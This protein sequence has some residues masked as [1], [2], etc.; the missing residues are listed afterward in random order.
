MQPLRAKVFISCGQKKDTQEVEV[1]RAIAK[2]L[3]SLGFDTYIAVQEQTLK[4]LKENIFSQLSTSEYFLFV[5]FPRE[6]FADSS[7]RRGS[8]FSHQELAIASYLDLPVIAFQQEGV[9]PL[10]GMMSILQA[11]AIPFDDAVKLPDMVREQV[12]KAGWRADWKN[13]LV[14]SRN[15]TEFDDARIT[16]QPGQ[17]Y[18]RFFHLSVENCNPYKLAVNCTA[19]IEAIRDAHT[20]LRIKRIRT[21]ELKWAGYVLPSVS[22]MPASYR[23]LDALFVLHDSP[24][25]VHFN[26]FTDSGYFM[27]PLQGPSQYRLDYVVVSENFPQARIS[28]VATVGNKIADATLI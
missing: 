23:E 20:N 4:G 2:V 28:V 22:I 17:P 10:N 18:A 5:D 12:K 19:Y 27:S 3:E 8:L 25:V 26:C 15:P 9:K 21:T 11:N 13:A 16:N 6:Q 14:I 1:A 24:Q 7:E